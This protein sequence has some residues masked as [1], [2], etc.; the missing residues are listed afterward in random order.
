MIITDLGNTLGTS[1]R[2]GSGIA[3]ARFTQDLPSQQLPLAL[4][5]PS[6]HQHPVVPWAASHCSF[7][8]AVT[9]T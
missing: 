6:L 7:S 9:F 4:C 3:P 5:F 1:F 2:L 8:S